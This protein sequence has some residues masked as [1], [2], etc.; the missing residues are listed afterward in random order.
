MQRPVAEKTPLLAGVFTGAAREGAGICYSLSKKNDILTVSFRLLSHGHENICLI[1]RGGKKSTNFL[2]QKK[3][4]D[5]LDYLQPL[6]I[7]TELQGVTWHSWKLPEC[8]LSLGSSE[9][10]LGFH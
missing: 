10:L 3:A 9:V 7:F 1:P 5:E 4:I 8:D 2:K 6:T